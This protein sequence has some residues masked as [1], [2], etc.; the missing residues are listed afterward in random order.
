MLALC[1]SNSKSVRKEMCKILAKIE[2]TTSMPANCDNLIDF[3]EIALGGVDDT[4]L[5]KMN[6]EK[7]NGIFEKVR[8]KEDKEWDL[9]IGV[10]KYDLRLLRSFSFVGEY[11]ESVEDIDRE[12]NA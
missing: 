5:T 12:L 4:R 9:V 3:I 8:W 2:Q 10:A 6:S 7:C 11:N 1:A